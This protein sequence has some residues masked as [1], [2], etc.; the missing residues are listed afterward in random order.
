MSPDFRWYWQVFLYHVPEVLPWLLGGL[1]G[2][3]AISF[4]PLGRALVGHLRT[5][6]GEADILEDLVTHVGA[7]RQE[8]AEALE[9][10]DAAERRLRQPPGKL[11]I[12]TPSSEGAQRLTTP[13]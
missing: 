5:R 10:L 11:P 4:S 2:L 8:L 1:V 7:M 6:R 12:E 3:V 13:H 9:R